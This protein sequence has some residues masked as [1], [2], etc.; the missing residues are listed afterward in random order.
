MR[1]IPSVRSTLDKV[2][3][4][5]GVLII[6]VQ[7]LFMAETQAQG[8]IIITGLFLVVIGTWRLGSVLL[9][10]R[11]ESL[12][13]RAEVNRFI[14]LVRSLDQSAQVE[15][16]AA[17]EAVRLQMHESVD[18]MAALSGGDEVAFA[19]QKKNMQRE[20]VAASA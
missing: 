7:V 12:A 1:S 11:R 19:T 14:D 4:L 3:T 6:L 17:I 2:V 8:A 20:P 5:V 9:P 18:Q 16:H 15:D 10:E 13:L